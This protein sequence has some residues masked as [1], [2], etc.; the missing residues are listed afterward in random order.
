MLRLISLFLV[1]LLITFNLMGE[2]KKSIP[3]G[4][5][6]YE[7]GSNLNHVK[8][9]GIEFSNEK[10]VF[11]AFFRVN[12]TGKLNLSLHYSSHL[13]G[14]KLNVDCLNK[15]FQVN[16]QPNDSVVFIGEV[17]CEKEG[18]VR[19]DFQSVD[20]NKPIDCVLHS[21]IVDC[22]LTVNLNF[23][24]D[25]SYYWGRRGP[26]VHM[27]YSIPEGVTAEWF[28]NEVTVP[29]GKDIIGSYFMSNG[30]GEGYFGMQVNSE[31]ERRVLFSVWSPFE[32]DNPNEI[33][34][35]HKVKLIKKGEA[36]QTGEFGNEGSG[37]QSFMQYNWKAGN[38]YKFLTRIRPDKNG[39]SEY[40]SYFYA[41]ELN[42]WKLIAQFLR[43][44]ISTYYTRPHSFLENFLTQQGYKDRI[45]YY[46]N[47]WI[48]TTD[49]KW[50][51][52]VK[53]K[54]T[55]DQTGRVGARKDFKG[56]V[57]QNGFFLE[58]GGFLDDYTTPGSLFERTPSGKQP[59]I[60]WAM[61]D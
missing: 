10:A 25:F 13:D 6:A 55:V 14:C 59:D 49:G 37:G 39:Y 8:N 7:V 26:S 35:E 47:Q 54:F 44:G 17:F 51:E 57:D 4:G 45:A 23:V 36:V 2:N 32:T 30:F 31:T 33:P 5:N 41:P 60:D 16:L 9:N 24:D 50:V 15:S 61:F 21:L 42:E 28:Y 18:Y 29:V 38:I 3:L 19:V 48:Y 1:S 56:G 52:L 34:E 27:T 11:S 58:N 43:P 46:N 22:D 12:N 53:G 20:K 40:T